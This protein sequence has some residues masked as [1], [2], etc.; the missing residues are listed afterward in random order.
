MMALEIYS[1]MKATL[2]KK[3]GLFSQSKETWHPLSSQFVDVNRM[4][5]Q[6]SQ[7]NNS[8]CGVRERR[9]SDL[10]VCCPPDTPRLSNRV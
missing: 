4:E 2:P 3:G 8:H 10:A 9:D 5:S 1:T 7:I 6:D